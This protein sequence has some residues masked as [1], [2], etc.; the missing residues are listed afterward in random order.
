MEDHRRLQQEQLNSN[1]LTALRAAI[2][3]GIESDAVE[4]FDADQLLKHL[5][6]ERA[7]KIRST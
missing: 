5:R 3:E 1:K 2:Q 4:H 7:G 6:A